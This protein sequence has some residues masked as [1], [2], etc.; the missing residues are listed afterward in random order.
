MT[1][2]KI[3]ELY[4]KVSSM[5]DSL[6]R[7]IPQYIPGCNFQTIHSILIDSI[8]P[9]V[10]NSNDIDDLLEIKL[11]AI[12]CYLAPL[13]TGTI[14]SLIQSDCMEIARSIPKIES[15]DH[16]LIDVAIALAS[17]WHRTKSIGERIWDKPWDAAREQFV[18]IALAIIDRILLAFERSNDLDE[19]FM[20][21]GTL[22][23]KAVVG[24]VLGSPFDFH[25]PSEDQT[26]QNL[27]YD[28]VKD[29][30]HVPDEEVN[31][32]GRIRHLS[33]WNP[34][35]QRELGKPRPSL[36]NWLIQAIQGQ[37]QLLHVCDFDDISIGRVFCKGSANGK[38]RVGEFR[39]GLLYRLM[40]SEGDLLVRNAAFVMC[41]HCGSSKCEFGVDH[42]ACRSHPSPEDYYVITKEILLIP[43]V[44]ITKTRFRGFTPMQ[45]PPAVQAELERRGIESLRVYYE[46]DLPD[47]P[48][49]DIR[50]KRSTRVAR[51]FI[52]RSLFA[53]KEETYGGDKVDDS[54]AHANRT[55]GSE[56]VDNVSHIEQR[57]IVERAL[58]KLPPTQKEIIRMMFGENMELSDIATTLEMS[59]EEVK[60]YYEKAM[61]RLRDECGEII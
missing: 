32:A 6:D 23:E 22:L 2:D 13:H 29:F 60:E 27:A 16:L 43:G 4:K 52:R 12:L 11:T 44:Y 38:V 5:R 48:H 57:S 49:D 30:L 9:N 61:A 26:R 40:A 10:I 15:D 46:D 33:Y 51:P 3:K 37:R 53:P 36:V 25:Y 24:T 14:P 42:C 59:V 35:E 41:I 47:C 7:P 54:V 19:D 39:H 17:G 1:D 34:V 31:L 58:E 56:V 8:L 45:W 55:G 28:S 20:F 50:E 18:Q 21:K